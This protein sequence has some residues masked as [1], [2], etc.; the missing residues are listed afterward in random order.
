LHQD[1]HAV[2]SPIKLFTLQNRLTAG[3]IC[4]CLDLTGAAPEQQ[5]SNLRAERTVHLFQNTT[6]REKQPQNKLEMRRIQE[7]ENPEKGCKDPPADE[8]LF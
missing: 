7:E 5:H 2:F 6:T 8:N 1:F 3:F 4:R